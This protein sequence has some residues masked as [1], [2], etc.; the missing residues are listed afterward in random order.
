MALVH[1]LGERVGNPGAN[2]NHGSLLDAKFRSDS[3][4]S[5]ETNAANIAGEPVRVFRH[6]LDGVGAVGL[7]DPH[8]PGRTDAVAV[9]EDHHL[10][11]RLLSAQAE[12]MLVART[13]DAI[14]LAQPVRCGLDDIE[15]FLAEGA[16]ELFGCT[17]VRTSE[18]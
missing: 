6:D 12:R 17:R 14:D 4:G 7:E 13:A 8:C 9:Q 2:P 10:P 1:R 16:H 5:L 15:D 18:P 11:H 3:V